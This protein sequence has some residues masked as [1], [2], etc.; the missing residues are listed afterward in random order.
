MKN[1]IHLVFMSFFLLSNVLYAKSFEGF[2]ITH[3]VNL[4]EI[5][6]RMLLIDAF[7]QAAPREYEASWKLVAKHLGV[8]GMRLE[9]LVYQEER[10]A[11]I[12]MNQFAFEYFQNQEA[13]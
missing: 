6:H 1:C 9:D 3:R 13:K 7:K 2:A 11:I 8:E 5:P 12:L 4:G 10:E